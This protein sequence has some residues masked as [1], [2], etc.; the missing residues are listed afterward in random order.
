VLDAMLTLL[1]AAR[2]GTTLPISHATERP[3]AVRGI[4]PAAA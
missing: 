4:T 3:S 1:D 2:K